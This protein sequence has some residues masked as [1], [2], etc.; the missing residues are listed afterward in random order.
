MMM[1]S[2]KMIDFSEIHSGND[3]A[4]AVLKITGEDKQDSTE[5][6]E[7]LLASLEK[8]KK[9]KKIELAR[10]AKQFIEA[11]FCECEECQGETYG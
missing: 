4:F 2:E 6:I 1:L 10:Q 8:T 7:S 5:G 9:K 3:L 11:H